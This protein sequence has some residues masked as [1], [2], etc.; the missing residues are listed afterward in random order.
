LSSNSAPTSTDSPM[1]IL[2]VSAADHMGGAEQ[3]GWLLF[4]S[5]RSRGHHA[6]LAVGRKTTNHPAVFEIPNHRRRNLWA[7]ACTTAAA[8]LKP[9]QN[10]KGMKRVQLILRE[11][12]AQ[13]LRTRAK[14]RGE[15][16][17]EFPGTVDLLSLA[18][19]PPELVHCHNLHSPQG[20]FDLRQLPA[21]SQRQPTIV[22]LHDAWL[23]AGH[24]AHS[25]ECERWLTGCGECPDL[26]IYPPMPRDA[27]ALNW[28]RK[29][30]IFAQCRLHVSACSKWLLDR[31]K[32]SLM[33][34]AIADSRVIYNGVDRTIFKPVDRAAARQELGLPPTAPILLFAANGVRNNCFKDFRTMRAALGRVA[35]QWK[36]EP[37]VFVALGEESPEE[38]IGLAVIRFIP[39]QRDPRIVARYH[40]AADVYL[41]AA[42][43][44]SLP[45]AVLEAFACERPVVASDVG[46]IPEQI[47]EG[48]NGHMVPVGDSETFAARVLSLLSDPDRRVSMGERGARLV[49]EKFDVRFQIEEYLRWYQEILATRH[50]QATL[51]A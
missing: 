23:L 44:D 36:G 51:K 50:E 25:F 43:A 12:I 35:E 40:Q 7:R 37:I 11:P 28:Q 5:Q 26:S 1:R 15:E 8:A 4:D 32:Q 33:A 34:P 31:A 18:P 20:Y 19:S 27:T 22:T 49:A 30:D 2:H 14:R 13:P 29:R 46:G 42:R 38:A 10:I 6:W 3:V 16:D 24:C 48:V 45:I 21:I 41:H 47:D 39:F 17:F 9:L